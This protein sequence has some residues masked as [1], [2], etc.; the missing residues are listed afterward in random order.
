MVNLVLYIR[1]VL[2]LG[3]LYC[4]ATSV[5]NNPLYKASP[6]ARAGVIGATNRRREHRTKCRE[7]PQTIS[8]AARQGLAVLMSM[9]QVVLKW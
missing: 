1:S 5:K 7:V 4:Q 9:V 8:Q 6:C 3:L 2:Q